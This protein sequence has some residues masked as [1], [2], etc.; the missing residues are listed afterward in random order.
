MIVYV[1]AMNACWRSGGKFPLIPNVGIRCM[2]MVSL[3]TWSLHPAEVALRNPSNSGLCEPQS[4][5]G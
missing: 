5:S 2:L 4:W 3:T 1:H